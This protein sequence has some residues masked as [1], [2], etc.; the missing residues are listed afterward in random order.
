MQGTYF[1]CGITMAALVLWP[2]ETEIIMVSAS[3]KIQLYWVNWRLKRMARK[4]HSALVA[5]MTTPLYFNYDFE[6]GGKGWWEKLNRGWHEMY[7]YASP[8]IS[9]PE[10]RYTN[11]WDR[12]QP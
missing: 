9:P 8:L 6:H 11:L 1:L 2:E 3:L 10:F 7:S 12:D 5:S 4:M